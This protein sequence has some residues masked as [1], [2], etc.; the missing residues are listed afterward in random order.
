MHSREP[1]G[2]VLLIGECEY[3]Y[4]WIYMT[5]RGI[6]PQMTVSDFNTDGKEE[7]AIILNTGSGTGISISELHIIE[8]PEEQ[9]L[10]VQSSDAPNPDK[11]EDHLFSSISYIAQLQKAVGFKTM[12]HTGELRGELTVGS[13]VYQV[14]LK[15]LQSEDYGKINDELV[16][17][18]IVDFSSNQN[19]LTVE[20]KV[21]ITCENFISP[22]Y[23]GAMHAD[24]NYAQ[25]EFILNNFRFEEYEEK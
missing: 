21:G 8:I 24:V 13:E 22:I 2:V 9:K 14:N 11:L 17:G 10:P 7:L 3:K 18:N 23:I 12:N 19:Q 6:P 25:G 5:P 16:W 1:D 15:D 20:F 4:D